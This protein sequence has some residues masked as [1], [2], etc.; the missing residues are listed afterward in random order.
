M[1]KRESLQLLFEHI[2]GSRNVYYQPP[3]DISLRYPCIVYF[4]SNIGNTHA[5]NIPYTQ[6]IEYEV[7]VI[8]KNPESFIVVEVSK[9]PTCQYN[10]DFKSAN[11]NHTVFKLKY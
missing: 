2:L 6:V 10:R 5:D 1:T 9:L 8:D 7:T 4:R 3:A 11:L